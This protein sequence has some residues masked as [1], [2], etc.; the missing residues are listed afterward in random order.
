MKK[1]YLIKNHIVSIIFS[2]MA[3]YL[4]FLMRD[5]PID[6]TAKDNLLKF[7]IGFHIIYALAGT[8]IY[9]MPKFKKILFRYLIGYVGVLLIFSSTLIFYFLQAKITYF[10]QL[11]ININ[12]VFILFW[13]MLLFTINKK[14]T[15][16]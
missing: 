15:T 16:K 9:L 12:F 14:T 8:T 1:P 4:L 3:C 13:S 6:Q 10:D 2:F 7:T 11:I 5:L